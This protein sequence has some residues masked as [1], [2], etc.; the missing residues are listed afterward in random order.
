MQTLKDSE[1]LLV[2]C[3]LSLQNLDKTVSKGR[4]NTLMWNALK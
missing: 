2:K 4:Q 3:C 1:S